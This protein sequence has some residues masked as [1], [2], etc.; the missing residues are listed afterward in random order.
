MNFERVKNPLD[1]IVRNVFGGWN[2]LKVAVERMMKDVESDEN[3]KPGS[4]K[5][6]RSVLGR[7]ADDFSSD[8]FKLCMQ[9]VNV[10]IGRIKKE[11]SKKSRK[12]DQLVS[13]VRIEKAKDDQREERERT[14]IDSEKYNVL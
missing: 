7:C 8:E 2:D 5:F 13:E 10:A 1:D 11:K 9:A 4:S 14:G 12:I 3:I 6:T